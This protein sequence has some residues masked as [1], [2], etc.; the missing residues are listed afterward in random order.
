MSGMTEQDRKALETLGDLCAGQWENVAEP[1]LQHLAARL[2]G[3]GERMAWGM[4]IVLDE[5][6]APDEFRIAP[7][8]VAGDAVAKLAAQ[9]WEES[10]LFTGFYAGDIRAIADRILAALAQDRAALS[11]QP[12]PS[13]PDTWAAALND[14]LRALAEELRAHPDGSKVYRS[15]IASAIESALDDAG[16]DAMESPR[17]FDEASIKRAARAMAHL[18]V[19]RED[20]WGRYTSDARA[21]LTAALSAPSE[22]V[23]ASVAVPDESTIDRLAREAYEVHCNAPIG[24]FPNDS[25]F[26]KWRA[27]VRHVLAAAPV[28]PERGVGRG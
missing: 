15:S 25:N 12:A 14:Q 24:H 19:G 9:L 5:S 18:F 3:D 1:A 28:A 7:Q 13:A 10:K 6:L 23:A 4:P 11:T 8:P 21:V 20:L 2:R 17:N 26:P 27:V 22:Q 16:A